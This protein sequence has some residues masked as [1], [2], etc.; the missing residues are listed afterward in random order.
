M[1]VCGF[2][3]YRCSL[4]REP[5]AKRNELGTARQVWDRIGAVKVPLDHAAPG[6]GAPAMYSLT[7]APSVRY[8]LFNDD[9]SPEGAHDIVL[10]AVDLGA[11]DEHRA[12]DPG[13]TRG[14]PPHSDRAHRPRPSS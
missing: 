1:P 8:P 13:Q 7:G 9:R 4:E 11:G 14:H 5:N 12:A 2:G 3:R 10:R 6:P